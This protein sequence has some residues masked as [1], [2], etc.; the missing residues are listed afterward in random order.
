MPRAGPTAARTARPDATR[1]T[2]R[3]SSPK[4]WARWTRASACAWRRPAAA[5]T[6]SATMA[7]RVGWI[8]L[9]IMG[10][11]QAANLR[12]SGYD[13][14]VDNRTRQTAD[15]LADQHRATAA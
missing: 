2:A 14:T 8:G 9:G 4:R 6:G 3:A 5:G 11:R 15:A 12:R 13:L 1:S 7:E 10:S